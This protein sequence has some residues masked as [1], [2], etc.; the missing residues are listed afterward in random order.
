MQVVICGAGRVGYGIARELAQ[1]RN[2]VTV[3]D[4][5]AELIDRLTTDLDVRGVVGHGSHPE[6]LERAG[7]GDADMII[8]VTHSDEVNMVAC[9]VAHSLFS[10]PTKIARV[11]SQS[12]LDMAWRDLFARQ[13]MPIDVIISPELEVGRAILRRLETPG[14]FNTL[15]FAN[16]Q[17]LLLG[18]SLSQDSPLD[19]TTIR[20]IDELFPDLEATV[21]GLVRDG[22]LFTPKPDDLLVAGDDL[23]VC[24][25]RD[26]ASRTLDIF[27]QDVARARRVILIGGGNVGVFV[28][29]EL[30]R[31][32]VRAKIIE[33]DK[34]HA[35]SA[36]EE[37][38]RT[39]VLHGDGLSREILKEAGVENAE[40]AISLT[41][42]DKVNVLA[43]VIAK[44]EGAKRALCLINDRTY[45]PL[46]HALDIDVFIDP[47]TITVST[48]LQHV[49]RGRITELYSIEDGEAEALEGVALETSPLVGKPLG[50]LNLSD[51]IAIGAVVRDEKVL[52]PHMDLT[53]REGDRVIVFAERDTITEVER[54]FRVS[55]AY[56]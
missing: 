14:A 52:M 48:I 43:S 13:N 12:Y 8:A 10:T 53:I 30:E 40:V 19:N 37:L 49:R 24:V 21:V 39:V 56:F 4:V 2:T 46:Q 27:G 3:V 25:A 36:A 47:R 50:E 5:S 11:R 7:V 23:Y 22:R 1:E 6:V 44:R 42:D 51:G 26:H 34:R 35:E 33:S 20:Q 38:A 15:P 29:Q 55:S 17:V 28:A 16:G 9:Q 54:M 31:R 45:E 41:N 18:L 32:G